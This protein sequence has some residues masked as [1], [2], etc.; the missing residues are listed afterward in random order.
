MVD[1]MRFSITLIAAAGLYAQYYVP[2]HHHGSLAN[3]LSRKIGRPVFDKT[4][5]QGPFDLT[6]VIDHAQRPPEN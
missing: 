1:V 4:E 6:L 2:Q 5:I 3:L